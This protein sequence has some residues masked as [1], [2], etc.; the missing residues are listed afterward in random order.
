MR[1]SWLRFQNGHDGYVLG[2]KN[3]YTGKFPSMKDTSTLEAG[4]SKLL[5]LGDTGTF[6]QNINNIRIRKTETC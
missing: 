4:R 3:L 1:I 2:N 6:T 5:A